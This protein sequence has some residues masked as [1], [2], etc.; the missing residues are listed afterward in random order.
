[1]GSWTG[2]RT[3]EARPEG[4]GGDERGEGEADEDGEQDP[5][6]GRGWGWPRV[7][8]REEGAHGGGEGAPLVERRGGAERAVLPTIAAAGGG[9][10]R[11]GGGGGLRVALGGRAGGAGRRRRYRGVPELGHGG[12][13]ARSVAASVVVVVEAVW[14]VWVPSCVGRDQVLSFGHF[15]FQRNF[16]KFWRFQ[17]EPKRLY[18][19]QHIPLTRKPC[20]S[21]EI[22]VSFS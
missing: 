2:Y 6:G 14:I 17:Y 16:V 7:L 5:V 13:G 10:E 4:R 19:S 8:E 22:L 11:G 3:H 12:A 21:S 1:M 20:Q 15:Q 9:E 18:C